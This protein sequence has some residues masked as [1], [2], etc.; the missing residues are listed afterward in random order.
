M[1]I[2]NGLLNV[3]TV[4]APHTGKPMRYN[5]C[6]LVYESDEDFGSLPVANPE[7]LADKLPS[8]IGHLNKNRNFCHYHMNMQMCLTQS[9]ACVK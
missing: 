6:S 8:H 9:Q 2:D 3:L 7:H 5:N 4:Y 1:V